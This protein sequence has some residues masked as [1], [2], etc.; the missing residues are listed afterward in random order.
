[1]DGLTGLRLWAML[2]TV[3]ALGGLV[4]YF[5]FGAWLHRRYYVQRR[6]SSEAWK[7][8]PKRWVSPKLHRWTL[9]VSAGNMALGGLLSGTFAY[10]VMTHGVSAL[11]FDLSEHGLGYTVLSTVL[12]F[13]SL[14]AAAYYTHRFLHGRFMFRH[15]HRWHHRVIATTPFTTVTMH[16]VEFTM[17]QATAFLPVFFLPVHVVSFIGM[18][19]YVLVFNILDHSGIRM[20]HWLPW[21]SSSAFH[22]DHHL[23][24]HCN[25][26]QNLAIFDRMHGT[27]RR[28]GRRYGKDVFG[29]RGAPLSPGE[30]EEPGDF[31]KY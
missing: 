11:Y 6:A 7:L 29:G 28:H 14:E 21:H 2:V 23:H 30:G 15:V 26:G 1:M 16:P 13:V 9:A 8:Q 4:I 17:L 18:L 31:V 3:S 19:V 25:Y 22:D 27:H 24:F 12:M 20:R 5:G 10:F